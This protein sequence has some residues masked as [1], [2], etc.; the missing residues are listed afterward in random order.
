MVGEASISLATACYGKSVNGNSGHDQNDV[1]YIA[2][3]GSDAVPGKS[4]KWNAKSY[5]EFEA[6]ISSLGDQLI[7]RIGG[8][9]GGGGTNPPPS[10]NCSWAGHCEGMNDTKGDGSSDQSSGRQLFPTLLAA[11]L[12]VLTFVFFL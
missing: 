3:P 12:P 11:T 8:G 4:A 1:L 6:S 2:F 7:Q 10:N 5:S 9:G